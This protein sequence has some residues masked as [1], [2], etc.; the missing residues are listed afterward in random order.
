MLSPDRPITSKEMPEVAA[1]I[2]SR[3]RARAPRVHCITNVV[4][5][6]FSANMLLA[7]GAIPSM[8]IAPDEVAEF[9]TRADALLI[10]LGT[11]DADRRAASEIAIGAAAQAGKPWLLDPVFVDRSAQRA[12]Y[13]RTLIAK[14]PRALRLNRAEFTALSGQELDG[15]SLARYADDIGTTIGMTGETDIVIS[16]G[17]LACIANGD[18]MMARVTAMGCAAG[19]LV[20]ACLAVESDAWVATTSG[21]LILGVA[22]QLAGAGAAGPGSF[23]PAILDK[24]YSLDQ[25]TLVER[26]R[27]M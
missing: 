18:P 19:A 14:R 16:G 21:L 13:A 23:V 17:R 4:A 12:N 25:A 26:A 9:V 5:Q 1:D 10:N 8:T 3:I 2:L 11:F 15:A 27:V 6:N 22:G 24:I 20:G 7:A